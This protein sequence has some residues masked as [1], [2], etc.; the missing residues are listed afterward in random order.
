MSDDSWSDTLNDYLHCS[1]EDNRVIDFFNEMVVENNLL[2]NR[3]DN[4]F[5]LDVG[6]GNGIKL[7]RIL[8]LIVGKRFC[9]Q[10]KVTICEPSSYWKEYMYEHNIISDIEKSGEIE[11]VMKDIE[12]YISCL[13]TTKF[14]FISFIHVIYSNAI[15]DAMIKV[16]TG[17]SLYQGGLIWIVLEDYESDFYKIRILLKKHDFEVPMTRINEIELEL[18]NNHINYTSTKISDK[19]CEVDY[20]HLYM[21]DSYWLYPFV[22]GVNYKTYHSMSEL[23]RKKCI[24]LVKDYIFINNIKRLH[25]PDRAILIFN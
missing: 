7:K 20:Y 15:Q 25:I 3:N 22:L 12:D 21:D 24:S 14:N 23:R 9:D 18:K 19:Y 16:I 1:N 11:Y 10:I 4:I 17:N 2:T 8:D 13:G 5:Y 6:S